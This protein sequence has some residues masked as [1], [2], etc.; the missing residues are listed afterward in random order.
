MP[1]TMQVRIPVASGVALLIGALPWVY[2]EGPVQELKPVHA[3]FNLGAPDQGPFPSD[4]FTAP[5]PSNITG[6][7]I[8]LPMPDCEQRPSDCEDLSILNSLDG[9]SLQPRLSI[10]FDAPIDPATVTKDSILLIGLRSA[11]PGRRDRSTGALLPTVLAPFSG[12]TVTQFQ[13]LDEL[14][15]RERRPDHECGNDQGEDLRLLW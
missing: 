7:R 10:S 5:E 13:R 4:W 2:A 3:R 14:G 6:R 11:A 15:I 8:N 9:F 1:I 12:A